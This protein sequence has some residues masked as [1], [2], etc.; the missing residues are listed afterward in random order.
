MG[1]A[2]LLVV[3]VHA[4]AD[5]RTRLMAEA[6]AAAGG[7][8]DV[9]SFRDT[10]E[11]PSEIIAGVRYIRLPVRRAGGNVYRRLF[12]EASF[13]L[14]AFF[15]ASVLACRRRYALFHSRGTPDLLVFCGI[16]PRLLGARVVID[17]PE[18]APELG[19]LTRGC[20]QPGSNPET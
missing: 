13:S 6:L 15:F 16:L 17:L 5:A 4:S 18:P 9:L 19:E 20:L 3:A 11:K 10:D 7:H 12:E 1:F 8:V 14:F 2:S